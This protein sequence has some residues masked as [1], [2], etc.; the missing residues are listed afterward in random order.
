MTEAVTLAKHIRLK[1]K[2]DNV[3]DD[4]LCVLRDHVVKGIGPKTDW[5]LLQN[6]LVVLDAGSFRR[7]AEIGGHSLNTV[8]ARIA[9]LERQTGLILIERRTLGTKATEAAQP[10]VAIA[11][12][13]EQALRSW[14][15]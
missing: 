9:E 8:R 13:M 10:L 6:F 14:E 3:S 5:A 7:A 2:L 11:R 12:E 1:P 15:T 4:V